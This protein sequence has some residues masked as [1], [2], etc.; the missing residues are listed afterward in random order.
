M[1]RVLYVED[2][3]IAAHIGQSLL[4]MFPNIQFEYAAAGYQALELFEASQFD[5][6]LVDIGLP[7]MSGVELMRMIQQN[8]ANCPPVVAITAHVSPNDSPPPGITR[9]YAK[10]LTHDLLSNILTL[11][12]Q[13]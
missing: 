11:V 5:L 7:D 10:P 6:L 3:E 12:S 13:T 1:V 9:I 4:K 8:F 2:D